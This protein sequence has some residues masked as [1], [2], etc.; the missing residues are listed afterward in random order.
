M[1]CPTYLINVCSNR[2][3]TGD[4]NRD[5]YTPI[6][7]ATYFSKLV[8]LCKKKKKKKSQKFVQT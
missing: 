8:F 5:L 3:H 6:Q 7:D 4:L 2:S 1:F